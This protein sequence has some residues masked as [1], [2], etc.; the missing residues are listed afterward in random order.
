MLFTVRTHS[1]GS[2]SPRLFQAGHTEL[3]QF[4]LTCQ[5]FKQ[6]GILGITIDSCASISSFLSWGAQN[7]AQNSECGLTCAKQR[8]RIASLHLTKTS[9]EADGLFCH[10]AT[11]GSWATRNARQKP[12]VFSADLLPRQPD[13]A[14]MFVRH[15]SLPGAG[16][17]YLLIQTW[18]SYCQPIYPPCQDPCE[19]QA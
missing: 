3:F 13:P 9:L 18:Q 14:W 8:G 11:S 19:W 17:V 5:S 10:K 12:L 7:R 16:L 15:Y 2:P 1:K 6:L 4:L